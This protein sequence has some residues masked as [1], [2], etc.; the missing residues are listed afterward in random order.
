MKIL[1][2]EDEERSFTRLKRLLENIDPSFEI[3]GPITSVSDVVDVLEGDKVYDII[4]ADIRL[5][6][7]DVFEA[8]IQRQPQVPVVFTTAYNEY[9]LEAFRSNGVAYI[10]KPVDPAELL[11]AVNKAKKLT[12]AED[13]EPNYVGL[14]ASLGLA[15][16]GRR[17]HFL[18]QTYDGYTVL[19]VSDIS[20]ITTDNGITR[21]YMSNGKS[22]VLNY[23]L[24]DIETMLDPA[25]FFRANRQCIISIDSIERL[26]FHFNRKLSVKLKGYRDED[27]IVSKER[28]ALLKEW[29]DR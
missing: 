16:Q 17:E 2:I 21:A 8:F 10:L 3:E 5:D 22:E 7:G 23:S 25:R 14:I 27:V 6:D 13:T 4:F 20:H 15:K 1:I 18:V 26:S 28:S 9:A 19:N 29:I 12:T 11:E 24:N